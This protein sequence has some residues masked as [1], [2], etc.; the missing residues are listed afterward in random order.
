[1]SRK[2]TPELL[3]LLTEHNLAGLAEELAQNEVFSVE[4]VDGMTEH[5][6]QKWNLP[7]TFNAFLTYVHA[8]MQQKYMP[9]TPSPHRERRGKDTPEP[10]KR[11]TKLNGLLAQLLT[12][13]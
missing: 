12:L 8:Y 13:G 3:R 5:D 10:K 2:C 11:Q 6:V 7:D 9:R 4:D 1:M